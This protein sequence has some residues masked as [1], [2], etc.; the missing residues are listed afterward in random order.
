MIDSTSVT[1]VKSSSWVRLA[2]PVTFRKHCLVDFNIHSKAPPHQGA[3]SI[4]NV[5][6]HPFP[7]RW[8]HTVS[9]LNTDFKNFAVPLNVL[10]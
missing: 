6:S 9:S 5:H 10:W 3:R 1:I 7:D 8:S 4:L 2:R